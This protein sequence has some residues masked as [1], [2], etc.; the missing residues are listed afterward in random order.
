MKTEKYFKNEIF[1][2]PAGHNQGE[3]NIY[4]GVGSEGVRGP[5]LG[6]PVGL[7]ACRTLTPRALMGTGT[8]NPTQVP[9]VCQI[10]LCVSLCILDNGG[11]NAVSERLPPQSLLPVP[12]GRVH[13]GCGTRCVLPQSPP[14]PRTKLFVTKCTKCTKC[15]LLIR[16]SRFSFLYFP[17]SGLGPRCLDPEPVSAF[18]EP[19]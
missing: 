12:S 10:D 3:E 2:A 15:L 5:T 6:L 11:V 13:T 9:V 4:L 16:C 7:E 19:Y 8:R 17:V 14:D 18:T 1:F